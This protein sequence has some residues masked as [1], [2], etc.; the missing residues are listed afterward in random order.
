MNLLKKITANNSGILTGNGTNTYLIGSKDL[1]LIDPGPNLEDHIDEIIKIADGKI[2]RILVTHTHQD[3]SSA[4]LPI[5]KRIGV[6]MYGRMING[7]SS[8]EDRTFIPNI[9]LNHLDLIKTKEYTIKAIHSPGHAS[10]HLCYLI[11]NINCLIS[12]DLIMDGSTVVISPPDGDMIE[13]ISSLKKLLYYKIDF[14]APGHGN[15]IFDI[16]NTIENL[17]LHRFSREKKVLEKIIEA[18]DPNL[19][20]LLKLVYDDVPQYKHSIA[21]FSLQAHLIKLLKEKKIKKINNNFEI[22]SI[23]YN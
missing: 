4:A 14:I 3:H 22:S 5:S 16:K 9:V 10:N 13:Y 17:I 12:G 6:P 23:K 11:K 19:E 2:R 15:Y 8:N 20:G 18:V 21:K 7:L 1:T